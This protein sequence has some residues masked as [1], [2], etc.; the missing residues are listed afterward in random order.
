[1]VGTAVTHPSH[2]GRLTNTRTRAG[3]AASMPALRG[4]RSA[5]R[6]FARS[7][8]VACQSLQ[9]VSLL[10]RRQGAARWTSHPSLMTDIAAHA[11]APMHHDGYFEGG[12]PT[13][14]AKCPFTRVMSNGRMRRAGGTP[15]VWLRDRV[16]HPRC[17]DHGF[18]KIRVIPASSISTPRPGASGTATHPSSPTT[19]GSRR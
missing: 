1:M 9:R 7:G 5:G 10:T 4:P 13:S 17:V 11:G 2:Q 18:A 3:V 14:P 8:T 12:T 15:S 19:N 16:P 6:L